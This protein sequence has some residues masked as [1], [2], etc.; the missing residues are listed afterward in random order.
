MRHRPQSPSSTPVVI[1]GCVQWIHPQFRFPV[2]PIF[3]T[4]SLAVQCSCDSMWIYS[5]FFSNHLQTPQFKC[6]AHREH[7]SSFLSSSSSQ[8]VTVSSKVANECNVL[9]LAQILLP[10]PLYLLVIKF[11]LTECELSGPR[12]SKSRRNRKNW[13]RMLKP[14]DTL[15]SRP[16]TPNLCLT[17]TSQYAPLLYNHLPASC[18]LI[19][20]KTIP[21]LGIMAGLR[22]PNSSSS[23]RSLVDERESVWA[24][25]PRE[26]SLT[27]S[28][29]PGISH[30]P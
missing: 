19:F 17:Q 11:G 16:P 30:N 7:T 24:F 6:S 14:S 22:P 3:L 28:Y 21:K 1:A 15:L 23:P 5:W 27:R 9:D 29:N 10:L 8:P 18:W 12:S 4:R 25:R 2:S 13:N 26:H 20:V